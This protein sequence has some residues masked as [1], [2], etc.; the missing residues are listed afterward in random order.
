MKNRGWIISIILMFVLCAYLFIYF[1]ET[2][3][4]RKINEIVT[5]QKIHAKQAA[6]NFYEL[7]DKWNSVLLYLSRDKNVIELNDEGSNELEKLFRVFKDEIA[8]I[9][10]ADA[11]GKIIYTVPYYAQ[12]IGTDIS[13]QKHMVKILAEHQPVVSDVFM[14]V[15][16][17]QAIVIH[18]PIFKNGNYE[19]SIAF[20]LNFERITKEILGEIKI[21]A[22]VRTWLLSADG[23]ELY[24]E[25]PSHVGKS[26][27]ETA[28]SSV[29]TKRLAQIM[30]SGKEGTETFVFTDKE[31]GKVDAVVYFLPIKIMNTFWSLAIASSE[32][33]L[34][35]PLFYFSLKL[36]II[37]SVLFSGGVY[38]SNY[39]FKAR[40][41][42]KESEARKKAE[43]E[44]KYSEER[45][46]LISEVAS[47]YI[48]TTSFDKNGKQIHDWISGA[49]P[50]MTEYSFE[51]YRAIG[52][53]KAI[54]HPDDREIDENA[55]AL[56]QKNQPANSEVRT[57]TKTGKI[58]WVRVLARPLWNEQENK[59]AGI[60]G[61]VQNITESKNAENALRQ[62]EERFRTIYNSVNDAMFIHDINTGAIID[63]NK[64]MEEMFCITRDE[65][66]Q[67]EIGALSAGIS[68][69][70][71]K[72]A[73][74]WI[75]K[76]RDEG[77]QQ[78]EWLAKTKGGLLFW[79]EVSMSPVIIAGEKRLLVS[80]RNIT[81]RKNFEDQ[82]NTLR[83]AVE[84]SPV[85]VVIT[86]VNGI[87]EYVNAGFCEISG[88]DKAE[89]IKKPLR[90]LNQYKQSK[91]NSD[92]I[93]GNLKEGKDWRGDYQNKRKDGSTY[94]ENTLI[95]PVKDNEGKILH[96]LAVQEDITE[97]KKFEMQLLLAKEKA[98]EMYRL[99]SNFLSNMSHE[100]R[101]PLVGMLGLTELLYNELEGD[102]KEFVALINKS[103]NRLLTTLNT[104][105]N[106]SK[107]EAEKVVINLSR[108]SIL[109]TIREEVK[110]F[111]ALA[112]KNGLFIHLDIK[113]TEFSA[114]T[115]QAMIKEVIDNLLN[116]AIRF[117]F[118]GG[119]IVS[120]GK[121]EK[122]ITISI[123]DTGI[124]IPEDKIK[125][126]FEEFRQ[127]SEGR[128]R[129]FEGTGLGLT[130]VKKYVDAL[131]GEV[132]VESKLEVGSNFIVT[133]PANLVLELDVPDDDN[134]ITTA[135]S[136][137]VEPEMEKVKML[138][139]EDD[140]INSF[141]ISQ[142]L[143]RIGDI[144][145]VNNAE[146]AINMANSNRYDM[147]L[148]DINLRRGKNG[149]EAA[150]A[151]RENNFYAETPI[152]ALTAYAMPDDR[153]E[154]LSHG[155]THYLSKPFSQEQIQKLILGIIDGL[156]K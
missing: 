83:L 106:Y 85:S 95:S 38:F 105:L 152:V 142:M 39:V 16:G 58:L 116:N 84:Q 24:C 34:G 77:P 121:T 59:L 73:L 117:T 91:V 136:S 67:T 133:I 78:F 110:L 60:Y 132:K 5:H 127:V 94:W 109:D 15:Q 62:S 7:I 151:I 26:A 144:T 33:E 32:A 90:I 18:Y 126:I 66:M 118:N 55:F 65:V 92:E 27:F 79:V 25:N 29:D 150:R 99:K 35:A 137:I 1:Y 112:I 46:R 148:M 108:V 81:E 6:R 80:V 31:D 107:I 49:F 71:S 125:I 70:S 68:P 20:L 42:L 140:E 28:D 45:H 40:A 149:V 17:F 51:E 3:R 153:T 103:S 47:D 44:L 64:T 82:L 23:I 156:K 114:I 75:F 145:E 36:L 154:F 143:K 88:Y 97:R 113:C 139:V 96:L 135:D 115:D 21:G 74:Q 104:L 155:F 138:L 123:K 54:V 141:A 2:E 10:R 102:N 37:F 22:S 86:D 147:I 119:I 131:K 61:A 13:K 111:E 63:V 129:N 87:I 11:K 122:E 100:L 50:A 134:I 48:F 128:G 4:E 76:A 9:T 69:Y 41:I 52:G 146:D 120:V 43:E 56:L 19:G 57:V 8:G 12:L 124:G 89:I 98:E 101:T 30:L 53:W 14:A 72:E 93:W 130:I